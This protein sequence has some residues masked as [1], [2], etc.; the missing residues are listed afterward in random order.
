MVVLIKQVEEE[1][2]VAIEP[3]TK[4][5]FAFFMAPK[6]GKKSPVHVAFANVPDCTRYPAALAA[7]RAFRSRSAIANRNPKQHLLMA[8][9]HLESRNRQL[10]PKCRTED[11]APKPPRAHRN[12]PRTC[13]N[14][15]NVL[16]AEIL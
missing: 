6:A 11:P 2:D 1:L 12:H 13:R 10:D 15:K 4:R 16:I 14:K 3:A 7:Y 5:K 8:L 9:S